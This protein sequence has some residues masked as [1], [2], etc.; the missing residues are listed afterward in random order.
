MIAAALNASWVPDSPTNWRIDRPAGSMG[1]LWSPTRSHPSSSFTS[2][3][4]PTRY[5]AKPSEGTARPSNTLNSAARRNTPSMSGWSLTLASIAAFVATSGIGNA[6]FGAVTSRADASH[7][8]NPRKTGVR[9]GTSS[10]QVS[11]S[12][13]AV[14][15]NTA[16]TKPGVR[17]TAAPSAS[18]SDTP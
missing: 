2:A 12:P 5:A 8:S 7:F 14:P 9:S 11:A 3:C 15:M 6:A 1:T 13:D 17:P 10:G 16:P 18:S 4:S